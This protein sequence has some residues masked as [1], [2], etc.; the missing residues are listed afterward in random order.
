MQR[1]L[2][3]KSHRVTFRSE[4]PEMIFDPVEASTPPCQATPP[5]TAPP[6]PPPATIET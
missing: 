2:H 4:R 3:S 1:R 6:L 5:V